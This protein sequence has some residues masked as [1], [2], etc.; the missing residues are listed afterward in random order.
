MTTP[1]RDEILA[2]LSTMIT[3]VIAEEWVQDLT[4]TM[5]TSFA[6]DLEL[7]SIEFVALAERVQAHFGDQVDFVDWL[8]GLEIDAII[9]LNLGELVEFI[10]R[11]LNA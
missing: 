2:A 5:D 11:C 9:R 8:S 10:E 3:E 7:E 4:F 6:E 1:Q